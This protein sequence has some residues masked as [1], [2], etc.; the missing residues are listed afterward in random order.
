MINRKQLEEACERRAKELGLTV[1][2]RKKQLM[3]RID[4]LA[5]TKPEINAPYFYRDCLK[6]TDH[7][8]LC[9]S[10]AEWVDVMTYSFGTKACRCTN[11]KCS[12]Y[13][14]R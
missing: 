3:D 12:Q 4:E 8:G 6:G 11:E 14:T 2:E 13:G 5:T 1:E 10:P 7:C 9:N